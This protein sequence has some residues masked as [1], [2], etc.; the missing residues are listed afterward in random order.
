MANMI[1]VFILVCCFNLKALPGEEPLYQEGDLQPFSL[2]MKKVRNEL[3]K[4]VRGRITKTTF[5]LLK[6]HFPNRTYRHQVPFSK[7][8][9]LLKEVNAQIVTLDL[10]K[11]QFDDDF[12]QSEEE[13][14]SHS[15]DVQGIE[16][17]DNNADEENHS[18]HDQ[19]IDD[20]AEVDDVSENYPEDNSIT[21]GQF[22]EVCDQLN[23][24]K[25]AKEV[26]EARLKKMNERVDK[27]MTLEFLLRRFQN[28]H[29]PR[30]NTS[31]AEGNTRI[32]DLLRDIYAIE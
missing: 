2:L 26:I 10:L 22:I 28:H 20:A 7:M 17:S 15:Y 1:C 4:R 12:T 27:K 13:E 8:N 23:Q 9:V 32:K 16:I 24:M 25:A 14:S 19:E 29:N 30:F 6:H 18:A 11:V 21:I 3:G 5:D 31:T